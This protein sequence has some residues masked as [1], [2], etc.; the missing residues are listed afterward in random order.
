MPFITVEVGEGR[1]L[2]QRRAFV[3][4][5]TEAAVEHLDATPDAV[6]I[7]MTEIGPYDLA[8]GGRFRGDQ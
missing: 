5:V 2:D 6:R 7:R 1:T 3:A 8:R 4:A